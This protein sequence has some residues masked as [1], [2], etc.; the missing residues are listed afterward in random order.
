M[1]LLNLIG[2]C[3]SYSSWNKVLILVKSLVGKK[4]R[5]FHSRIQGFPE[6]LSLDALGLGLLRAY[7][8]LPDRGACLVLMV[9]SKC[10]RT[11]SASV[12]LGPAHG[13]E[14]HSINPSIQSKLRMAK[15][16][17]PETEF[18]LALSRGS[19]D[20]TD[21]WSLGFSH[22]FKFFLLFV[23]KPEKALWSD[24][25]INHC[26]TPVF[27]CPSEESVLCFFLL[28]GFSLCL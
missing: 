6:I 28:L 18:L 25:I 12:A 3:C 7:P 1:V 27:A 22:I 14:S 4:D 16:C 8:V 2:I 15:L 19:S 13:R 5:C 20:Y 21:I 17:L 10:S 26:G 24:L 23:W 11:F 9:L